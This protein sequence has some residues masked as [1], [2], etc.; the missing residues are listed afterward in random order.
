[1]ASIA[2]PLAT[3]EQLATRSQRHGLPSDVFDAVF[4]AT[5]CLTQAAG[6]LLEQS[7]DV[8]ARACVI[9][10]R[11]LVAVPSIDYEYSMISA[12]VIY[13]VMKQSAEPVSSSRVC[14]VYSYLQSPMSPFRTS[15]APM[16]LDAEQARELMNS[17]ADFDSSLSQVESHIFYTL[18]FDLHVSLPY[19]LAVSYLQSLNFFGFSHS[20]ITLHVVK[21]LNTALL[22]PQ[23]LY[24]T[25]QP[26]ELAVAAIYLSARDVGA[27]MPTQEWWEVFDVD[28]ECL[29]FLAC[30]LSSVEGIMLQLNSDI[31]ELAEGVVTL[32]SVK[33][34]LKAREAALEK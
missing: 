12:A 13:T 5:Q 21:Y 11:Y 28:R 18:S 9:L 31:P 10:A 19:S 4:V 2:N 17:R 29:G 26:N 3:I 14:I 6:V 30:S 20:E 22:S 23:L 7:Q 34:I 8:I 15:K 27:K 25:H 16:P 33:Q 24:L 32:D 1:M